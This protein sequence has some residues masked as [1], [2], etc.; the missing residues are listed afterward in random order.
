MCHVRLRKII[1]QRLGLSKIECVEALSEPARY[2]RKQIACLG[3]Q[4]LIAPKPR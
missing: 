4:A 1:Q 3:S 2:G